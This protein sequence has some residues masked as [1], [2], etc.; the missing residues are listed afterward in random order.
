MYDL[1]S[2][3]SISVDMYF[4]GDSLTQDGTRFN[5][6][7]GGKYQV[8]HFH[9]GLGG[10]AANVAIGVQKHHY[11]TAVLG[12][13]GNNQFKELILKH[14]KIHGVSSALCQEEDE[15]M[16][17]SS[18]LLAP[19]GERTI[20]HYETPHEHIIRS[21]N[22]LKNIDNA[23]II[24]MSNLWR[25]PLEERKQILS[26]AM[27][28]KIVTIVNLGIADC[29]RPVTQIE[30]L[31]HHV[32]VLIVNTH[33]FAEIVKKPIEEIIFKKDVTD[34]MP[35][36]KTKIVVVTD[37]KNG[38]YAYLYGKVIHEEAVLVP[39]LKVLDTTGAGD[40]FSA[41]FIAGYLEKET[42]EHALHMGSKHGAHIVQKIGAN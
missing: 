8:E 9:A 25:V 17:I 23:K 35:F 22:D 13:I 3:G 42:I 29:R 38:S 33:E 41:G 6:A 24:Y 19:S 37:G 18:I 39:A 1:I 14:L 2:I 4:K 16:K 34:L 21:V 27:S 30:S 7:M 20:I 40:A 5:L 31:L 11:K 12:K 26:H 15:Y 10:G 32:N 36:L 28:R